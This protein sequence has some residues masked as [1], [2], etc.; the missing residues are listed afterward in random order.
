M[1]FQLATYNCTN[2]YTYIWLH[3][4]IHRHL[5]WLLALLEE[6]IRKI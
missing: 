6:R 1:L 2:V 4:T 3:I 5:D